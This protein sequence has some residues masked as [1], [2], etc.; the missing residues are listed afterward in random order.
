[1]ICEVAL[2]QL[3]R[4][5]C[6]N[7]RLWPGAST[8]T[9]KVTMPPLIEPPG[10]DTNVAPEGTPA[11]TRTVFAAPRP[12]LRTVSV[13]AYCSPETTAPGASTVILS[14]GGGGGQELAQVCPWNQPPTPSEQ[15]SSV[16]TMHEPL[17]WQHRPV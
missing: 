12:T 1:M 9:E 6:M 16:V 5:F 3:A 10:A 11:R 2:T 17:G 8:S 14:T 7:T 13:Y 4:T 15:L